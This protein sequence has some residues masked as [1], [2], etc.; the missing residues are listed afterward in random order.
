[1]EVYWFIATIKVSATGIARI[2]V[3]RP[4]K[5]DRVIYMEV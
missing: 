1:M 5:K 4:N 3:K 2:T